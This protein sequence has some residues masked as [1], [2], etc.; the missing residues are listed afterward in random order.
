MGLASIPQAAHTAVPRSS[1]VAAVFH[2]P[3]RQYL[4]H[5]GHFDG[6]SEYFQP[7]ASRVILDMPLKCKY[8]HICDYICR[9][10]G[11]RSKD[12]YIFSFIDITTI[13]SIQMAHTHTHPLH[14][15]ATR[16]IHTDYRMREK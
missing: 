10:G 15:H 7:L 13:F 2:C 3:Y 11:L 1:L 16:N 12:M 9:S 6:H 8:A 4:I 14:T 5:P